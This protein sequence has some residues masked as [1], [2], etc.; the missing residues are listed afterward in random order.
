[1]SQDGQLCG[2]FILNL[3]LSKSLWRPLAGSH[4]DAVFARSYLPQKHV[5]LSCFAEVK[6]YNHKLSLQKR[7][8]FEQD[9][10]VSH[11]KIILRTQTFFERSRHETQ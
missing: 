1:M 7:V 10:F 2:R 11:K 8:F 4:T 9:K 6:L 3:F 5:F